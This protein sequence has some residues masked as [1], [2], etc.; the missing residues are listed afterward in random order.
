[1]GAPPILGERPQDR[2]LLGPDLHLRQ[3]DLVDDPGR[4]AERLDLPGVEDPRRPL[5]HGPEVPQH[6]RHALREEA[7]QR[8][9]LVEHQRPQLPLREL[10]FGHTVDRS[11][12]RVRED[13]VRPSGGRHGHVPHRP[14]PAG[15]PQDHGLAPHDE[16]PHGHVPALQQP[17][18]PPRHL[19]LGLPDRG[20]DPPPR[21]P[22]VD[23]QGGNDAPVEGIQGRGGGRGGRYWVRHRTDPNER[24]WRSGPGPGPVSAD[25]LETAERTIGGPSAGGGADAG[26]GRGAGQCVMV[27]PLARGAR[28]GPRRAQ[29]SITGLHGERKGSRRSSTPP[30]HD[31][32]PE[33][34]VGVRD[35]AF[36]GAVVEQPPRA[37]EAARDVRH[38]FVQLLGFVALVVG[39]SGGGDDGQTVEDVEHDLAAG[40]PLD[41][42]DPCAQLLDARP[43][44]LR[45]VLVRVLGDTEPTMELVHA[46]TPAESCRSP[47]RRRTGARIFS[48][49][50]PIAS[51]MPW[52]SRW[53]RLRQFLSAATPT[54]Y[55]HRTRRAVRSASTW[56]PGRGQAVALMRL[57]GTASEPP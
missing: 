49:S 14:R 30:A 2:P 48:F 45:V 38:Q 57:R 12:E 43:Q 33:R 47:A 50:S 51:P 29:S 28:G 34:V 18:P 3:P 17:Q 4:P 21:R 1:M 54:C 13:A 24:G 27:R 32:H 42:A 37:G 56:S 44:R 36:V 15:H 52:V 40:G 19:P 20:R 7:G 31:A 25:G 55:R 22:P 41:R 16:P 53:T 26:E 35:V 8:G 23:L 6:R 39:L 9:H 5:V 11:R 10:Q 46:L